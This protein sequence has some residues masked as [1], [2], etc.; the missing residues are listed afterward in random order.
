MNSLSDWSAF[1]AIAGTVG[2]GLYTGFRIL[3]YIIASKFEMLSNARRTKDAAR[4]CPISADD[5]RLLHEIKASH[6]MFYDRLEKTLDVLDSAAESIH[7]MA[8]VL[9]THREVG[10]EWRR[11]LTDD[12]KE[13]RRTQDVQLGMLQKISARGRGGD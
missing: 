6:Q 9:R 11:N 4:N 12:V 2:G 5:V 3:N 1:V 8:S 10:E 7:D 13:L